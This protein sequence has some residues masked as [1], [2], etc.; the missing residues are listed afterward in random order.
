MSAPEVTF[1]FAQLQRGRIATQLQ[2]MVQA[3]GDPLQHAQIEVDDVPAGQYVGVERGNARTKAIQCR[4][5]IGAADRVRRHG[6]IAAVDDHYL[7]RIEAIEGDGEQ[8]LRFRIGLD[9]ECQH[10]RR[11]V[12]MRGFQFGIVEHQIYAV[13]SY[14]LAVDLAAALDAPLDE[15]AHREAHVGFEGVDACRVQAVT[16]IGYIV[17]RAH[18][19]AAY[20]RAVEGTFGRGLRLGHTQRQD[21]LDI[22]CANIEVS[23]L[24]VV[25]HEKCFAVGETAVEVHD[26]DAPP[27]GD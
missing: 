18:L 17:R 15:V 22:L 19:D 21:A 8:A 7:V 14:R 23:V 24:P 1:G 20:R 16:D 25:A 3:R 6:T 11:D 13:A 4:L 10:A 9:V 12:H 2:G 27:M 5:F 26:R